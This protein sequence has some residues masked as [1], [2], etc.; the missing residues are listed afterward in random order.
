MET[1]QECLAIV[2]AAGTSC[3]N[4]WYKLCR[5]SVRMLPMSG[6]YSIS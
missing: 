5:S 1:I 6:I 2:P 4:H 3:T